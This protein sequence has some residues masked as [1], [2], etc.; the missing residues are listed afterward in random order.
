MGEE[1]ERFL[2]AL[3]MT[4]VGIRNDRWWWL[5]GGMAMINRTPVETALRV[6]GR[7]S[8]S[9]GEAPHLCLWKSVATN[10]GKLKSRISQEEGASKNCM[11]LVPGRG[12][13]VG[14]R[15]AM[16]VFDFANGYTKNENLLFVW[17]RACLS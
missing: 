2:A 17:L 13:G 1:E 10:G 14:V 8:D 15:R 16:Q 12:R 5:G 6:D 4:G 3:E 9:W 11:G 7:V